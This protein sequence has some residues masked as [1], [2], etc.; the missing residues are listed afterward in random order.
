M[1]QWASG[2]VNFG[3][4]YTYVYIYIYNVVQYNLNGVH[5]YTYM[6]NIYTCVYIGSSPLLEPHTMGWGGGVGC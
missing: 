3:V 4:Y 2:D 1:W 5:M 6:Y